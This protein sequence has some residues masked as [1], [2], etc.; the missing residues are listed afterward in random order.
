MVALPYKVVS[1]GVL[2]PLLL[3]ANGLIMLRRSQSNEPQTAPAKE[4]S[5]L[6]SGPLKP[7]YEKDSYHMLLYLNGDFCAFSPASCQT[8]VPEGCGLGSCCQNGDHHVKVEELGNNQVR[9]TGGDTHC[10]CHEE[11]RT[12]F[13][14]FTVGE[15]YNGIKVV[16]GRPSGC[17][18]HNSDVLSAQSCDGLSRHQPMWF[19]TR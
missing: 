13:G 8:L 19:L 17:P 10:E 14:N 12:N 15:C 6:Q 4:N 9:I 3:S 11:R 5:T 18:T 16:K 7:A 1:L 2:C